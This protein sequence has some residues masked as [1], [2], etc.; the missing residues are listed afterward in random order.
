MSN[1]NVRTAPIDIGP[2]EQAIGI[3]TV[4]GW[5]HVRIRDGRLLGPYS[6][7]GDAE[8]AAARL[9]LGMTIRPLPERK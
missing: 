2:A 3:E 1:G 6:S 7:Q 5:P 8:K 9:G 4:N